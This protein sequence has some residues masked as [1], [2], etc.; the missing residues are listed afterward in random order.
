MNSPKC[1]YC[2]REMNYKER[3]DKLHV[4]YKCKS[5][6]HRNRDRIAIVHELES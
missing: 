1:D 5:G 3:I 6:I 4:I 2:N